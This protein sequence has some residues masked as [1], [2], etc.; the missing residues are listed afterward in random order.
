MPSIYSRRH[1]LRAALLSGGALTA[2]T[3]TPAL[4]PL[5][6]RAGGL[7]PGGAPAEPLQQTSLFMGT[8][9]SISVAQVEPGRAEE[10]MARPPAT[11]RQNG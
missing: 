8:M 9:V 6:A 7:L 5:A 10:G 2:A 11:R 1:F 3:L 4:L